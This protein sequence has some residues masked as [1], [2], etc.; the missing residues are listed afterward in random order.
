MV[1]FGLDTISTTEKDEMRPLILRGAPRSQTER[2]A[3]LDYCESDVDALARLLLAMLDKKSIDLPRALL[4]G[5]YMAAV[6][7]MEHTGIPIDTGMFSRLSW[8]WSDIQ[9]QLIAAIDAIITSSKAAHS[10]PIDSLT[11]WSEQVFR[12]PGSQA[13][14]LI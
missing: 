11:G 13:A 10:R 14:G 12:G 9:D 6:S 7:A 5:R 2:V 1:A 3:I 4:R 8:H